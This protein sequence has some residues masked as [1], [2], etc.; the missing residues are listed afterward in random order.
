MNGSLVPVI[1]S[2]YSLE[3]VAAAHQHMASNANIGK[4]LLATKAFESKHGLAS[5]RQDSDL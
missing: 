1:D 3:D 2:I 5:G 4:I